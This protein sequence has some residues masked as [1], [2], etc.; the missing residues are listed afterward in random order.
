MYGGRVVSIH[1]IAEKVNSRKP[2][3]LSGKEKRREEIELALM[4]GGGLP[5]NPY[6]PPPASS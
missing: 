3:P 6:I 4:E 5:P 1:S 2:T